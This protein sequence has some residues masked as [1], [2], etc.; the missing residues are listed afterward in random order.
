MG[1]SRCPLCQLECG[2]REQLITHVYQVWG[3]LCEARF[4]LGSRKCLFLTRKEEVGQ[5]GIAIS[6]APCEFAPHPRAACGC[7]SSSFNWANRCGDRA[8]VPLGLTHWPCLQHTA[9]AVVSTKSYL[10]PVCGRA[11]SSPGSLGRHLL[12]HSEDQLSNC[13]VCGARFTSHATFN[14]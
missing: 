5:E 3:A 6:V 10:C 11:L 2:S 9:A 12:I 7:L 1:L 13:A 4:C 8:A 14:R